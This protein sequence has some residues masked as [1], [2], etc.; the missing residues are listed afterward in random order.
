MNVEFQVL[1]AK[2]LLKGIT[3]IEITREG[4]LEDYLKEAE[5]QGYVFKDTKWRVTLTPISDQESIP[6][7]VNDADEEDVHHDMCAEDGCPV[8]HDRP[9]CAGPKPEPKKN[10]C[11]ARTCCE[12]N[13]KG[14]DCGGCS[15]SY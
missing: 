12:C 8:C 11:E 2:M 13:G 9:W 4:Y 3:E 15:E 14:S 6:I 5:T 1:V 7:P 10:P